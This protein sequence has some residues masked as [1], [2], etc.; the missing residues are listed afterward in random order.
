MPDLQSRGGNIVFLN[1]D[2]DS[3]YDIPLDLVTQL[4][5]VPFGIGQTSLNENIVDYCSHK[6]S[7]LMDKLAKTDAN[8]EKEVVNG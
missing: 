4:N 8:Y 3:L 1:D 5:K 6:K 7:E 2:G